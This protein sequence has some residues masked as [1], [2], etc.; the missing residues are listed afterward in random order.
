MTN[1]IWREHA[2]TSGRRAV[3][4]PNI[5]EEEFDRVQKAQDEQLRVLLMPHV[6]SV[7]SILDYGCGPGRFG[8]LLRDLALREADI[9]GFDPCRAYLRM[10]PENK[11]IYVDS[12]PVNRFGCVFVWLVLGGVEW[13]EAKRCADEIVSCLE[14]DGV[15]IFG[16]HVGEAPLGAWWKWRTGKVYRDLFAGRDVTLEKLGEVPQIKNMVTVF[17]GR[18]SAS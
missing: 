10:A 5:S 13:P 9:V 1:A 15:L 2:R 11:A 7:S 3:I 17:T 14:P 16:E 8:P 18:R 4:S 6:R 12:L